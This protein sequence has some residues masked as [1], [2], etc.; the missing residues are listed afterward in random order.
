MQG[1]LFDMAAK[2]SARCSDI[3]NPARNP[4]SAAATSTRHSH[5][6]PPTRID[7][8]G[9]APVSS[10]RSVQG[11]NPGGETVRDL[12]AAGLELTGDLRPAARHRCG[13]FG[14]HLAG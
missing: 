6:T 2:P 14:E 1:P 10:C 9:S 12:A 11:V 13:H 8:T 5:S 3:S 7:R 4:R